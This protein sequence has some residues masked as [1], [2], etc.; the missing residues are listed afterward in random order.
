[1][2]GVGE[3]L[4]SEIHVFHARF[5]FWIDF[6]MIFGSFGIHFGSLK[7]DSEI[8]QKFDGFLGRSWNGSGAP[9]GSHGGFRSARPGPTGMATGGV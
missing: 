9:K 2:F 6:L 3:V 5:C 4:F 7:M 1:M 8:D